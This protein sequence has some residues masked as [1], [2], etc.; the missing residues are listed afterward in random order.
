MARLLSYP[1]V[2]NVLDIGSGDGSH[3]RYMRDHG[4]NVIAVS[5]EPPAD[6]VGDYLTGECLKKFDAIWACH[7]LEHQPNPGLFLKKCFSDLKDGGVLAIT[8]P[9]AKHNIVG[10]HVTLWNAGLLLYNMI[11][12]GFD[13]REARVSRNYPA[14]EGGTPY[15]ISVIVKKREAVLPTLRMDTGDI[16]A[17]AKFFPFPAEHGFNG[18]L[19]AI[20]W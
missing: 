7:V 18:S 13:C 10:G 17:L 15:N 16:E 12:A 20:N 2:V 6:W 19:P 14:V 8:V 9:P 4:K 3:A 5:L 1:D 11:L